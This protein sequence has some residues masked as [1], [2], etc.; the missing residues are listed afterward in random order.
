MYALY[1]T[2][3]LKDTSLLILI[4]Y[5]LTRG[6]LLRLM[7]RE[8]LRSAETLL[9]GLPLGVISLGVSLLPDVGF[10]YPCQTLF[11]VFATLAGGLYVGLIVAVITSLDTV[12]TA[13]YHVLETL[14]AVIIISPLVAHTRRQKGVSTRLLL[15]FIAGALAQG[16]RFFLHNTFAGIWHIHILPLSVGLSIPSSGLGVALLLL[17]I[18]D[19]QVRADGI[20][21]RIEAEKQRAEAERANALAL[22]SQLGALRA[23]IRPHFL[24]NALNSIAELCC[25]APERAEIASLNLSDLMRQA[26]ETSAATVIPLSQ[27]LEMTRSYIQIEQERVGERLHILWQIDPESKDE[28]VVPFSVEVLVENAINHGVTPKL[29]PGTVTITIRHSVRHTLFA[30]R[31][32]GVGMP[33][34]SHPQRQPVDGKIT[35]GLQIL[36]RQ[37]ELRYGN[38]ARL[39]FF[40]AEEC[41]TLV[42]FALPHV[43][44]AT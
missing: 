24:F 40:S 13:P 22:E 5:L 34:E 31:D 8:R 11:A 19:S 41:G 1:F 23:R 2:D 15:G 6:Q 12:A 14:A 21:H 9:L 10:Q 3:F 44:R 27:E 42:V 28:M 43:A 38:R 4:A 26:L 16:F 32:D 18:N 30:V 39:R 25:I 7:F 29:G 36:N 33:R 17:V 35:H 20:Q 37:L